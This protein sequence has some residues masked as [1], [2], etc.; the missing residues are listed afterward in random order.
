MLAMFYHDTG[1]NY[2]DGK[3]YI[4]DCNVAGPRI[5]ISTLNTN[6]NKLLNIE[7]ML[8]IKDE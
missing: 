5:E 1:H 7:R 3:E 4:K 8:M 6:G 2:P